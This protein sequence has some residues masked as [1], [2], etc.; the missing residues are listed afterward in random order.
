MADRL[1]KART[2]AGLTQQ[3]LADDLGI[4]RKSVVRY[5]SG[6]ELRF[7]TIERWADACGVD[8]VWLMVG[9]DGGAHTGGVPVQEQANNQAGQ[10]IQSRL[11]FQLVA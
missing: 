9:D 11:D 10:F 4:S 1:A 7:H 8:P 6:A 3:Q 2:T 5:E